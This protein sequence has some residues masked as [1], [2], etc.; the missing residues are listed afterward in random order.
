MRRRLPK[1]PYLIGGA[2]ALA[3]WGEPRTTRDPHLVIELPFELMAAL[4]LE[5]ERPHTLVPVDIMLIC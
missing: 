3:A 5:L 4:S 1:V 2:V